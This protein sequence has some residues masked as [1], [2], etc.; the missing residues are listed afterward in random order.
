MNIIEVTVVRVYISEKSKLFT[1]VI[2]YLRDT[3][4]VRGFSVFRA[5]QGH[6]ETGDLTASLVVLS[7]DLP[8]AIEFF[9]EDQKT[10]T[11]IKHLS[12]MIKPEHIIWWSAKTNDGQT[13]S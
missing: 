11:A 8:L 5:I 1:P 13:T 6:G 7:L 4:K 12:T 3:A 9:D 10:T 2:K